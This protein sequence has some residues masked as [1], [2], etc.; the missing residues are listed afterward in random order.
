MFAYYTVNNPDDPL[1]VAAN[2]I[3]RTLYTMWRGLADALDE[4]LDSDAVYAPIIRSTG[5]SK[6][7][8]ENNL[9]ALA[10]LDELPQFR[11]LVETLHHLDMKRL[12]AVETALAMADREYFPQLDSRITDYLTPT[13]ENQPLPSAKAIK[14]RIEAMVNELDASISTDEEDPDLPQLTYNLEFNSDGTADLSARMNSASAA[15]VDKRVRALA[16]SRGMGLAEAH[17]LLVTGE[18]EGVK[19]TLN[20]YRAHDVDGAPTYMPRAGWINPQR[21]EEWESKAATIRDMDEMYDK[22]SQDYNTPEDIEAC[23]EGIDDACT[24]PYCECPGE[25]CDNDHTVDHDKGGPTTARNL[26][27]LCRRHHNLKTAGHFRY[28]ICPVTGNVIFLFRDGTWVENESD[29]PLVPENRRWVRTF[30]QRR[31]A[32]NEHRRAEAQE[33]RRLLN[34]AAEAA[35]EGG[36]ATGGGQEQGE[37]TSPWAADL[38]TEADTEPQAEGHADDAHRPHEP[39]GLRE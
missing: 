14:K 8:V 29:G 17:A 28:V 12:R 39:I 16:K 24:F 5:E 33:R 15:A 10:T 37:G 2:A 25:F 27:K 32:R 20:L 36:D 11:Q 1:A 38:L 4:N 13:R 6:W 7:M 26:R 34:E 23:V 30:R 19:V 31:T 9:Y 21:A 35:H 22:V 18:D 3:T